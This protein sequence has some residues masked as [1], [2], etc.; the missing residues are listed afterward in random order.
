MIR[1]FTL[2]VWAAS[3]GQIELQWPDN[4]Q[5]RRAIDLAA[6]S[7]LTADREHFGLTALP[8]PRQFQRWWKSECSASEEVAYY[9]DVTVSTPAMKPMIIIGTLIERLV[10]GCTEP[11]SNP[12][13]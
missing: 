4:T 3:G 6:L 11:I 10:G 7:G 12:L 5:W 9:D 2:L 1:G 13:V 8:G